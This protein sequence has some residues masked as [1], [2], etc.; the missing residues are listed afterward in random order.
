MSSSCGHVGIKRGMT[1]TERKVYVNI[2][3]TGAILPSLPFASAELLSP[4]A[5]TA[6]SILLK[7]AK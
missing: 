6:I 5:W 7:S 3:T 4:G 2:V 1:A